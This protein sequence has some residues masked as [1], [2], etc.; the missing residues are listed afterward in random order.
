MTRA[1]IFDCDGVLAQTERDGHRVAFNTMF[2]EFG[3]PVWWDPADYAVKLRIAGGKERLTSLLTADFV[4]E[5]GLPADPAE[6]QRLVSRWHRRKTEIYTDLIA[7]GLITPR[8]GV[9]RL[10]EEA[11][12]AGWRLA[13]ASTSAEPSV[14]AVLERVVGGDLATEFA[15]LAGDIAPRKKPA[16]DVYLLALDSLHC[17]GGDAVAIEDSGAGVLSATGAGI[18]CLVTISEYTRD[19][20]FA[21]AAIVVSDLG[22]PGLPLQ[23]VANRTGAK[24]DPY[25]SLDDLMTLLPGT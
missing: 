16:P 17:S 25:V 2:A 14:R 10:T 15:V 9:R 24:L 3:L 7:S 1:L 5:T 13:V 20:D 22:D 19:D 4:A 21:A 8:T 11:H 12:D 6:Q 23:V 18:G